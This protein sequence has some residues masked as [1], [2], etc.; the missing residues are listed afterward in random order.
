MTISGAEPVERLVLDTSA[1]SRLR[2]KHAVTADHIARTEAVLVPVTVLGELE[3]AFR[4][5]TRLDENRVA[6]ADFLAEDVVSVLDVTKSVARRFGELYAGLRRAGRAV[7]SN[8]I[9]IAAATL[10]CGGHLLTFDSDF[11]RF[12]ELPVTV[13]VA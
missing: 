2:A 1:Y 13:L 8:D 3:A 10:D 11:E 12:D 7:P 4:L 9:W 6:L 5:G